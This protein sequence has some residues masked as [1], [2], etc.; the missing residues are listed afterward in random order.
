MHFKIPE[1][2]YKSTI[3]LLVFFLLLL[4]TTENQNVQSKS[5]FSAKI[6]PEKV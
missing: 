6:F 5:L 2:L 4:R 1:L 3:K